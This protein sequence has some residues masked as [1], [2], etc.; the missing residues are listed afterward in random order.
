MDKEELLKQLKVLSFNKK[1]YLVRFPFNENHEEPWMVEGKYRLFFDT[2]S[3]LKF[4]T[5]NKGT[6]ILPY[7]VGELIKLLNEA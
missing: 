1:V 7:T 5:L 2:P 4:K 3:A 6:V